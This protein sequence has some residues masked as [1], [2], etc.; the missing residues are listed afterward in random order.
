MKFTRPQKVLFFSALAIGAYQLSR[1]ASLQ[2]AILS[3]QKI[4]ILNP[5]HA[6]V[7]LK[8]ENKNIFDVT[9]NNFS[10]GL[11]FNSQKFGIIDL[12]KG[13][14]LEAKKY[15]IIE[16]PVI[17]DIVAGINILSSM[18]LKKTTEGVINFLGYLSADGVD[19]P[20]NENYKIW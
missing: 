15:K 18:L 12:D 19:I 11:F 17:I 5:S 1:I 13:F 2:K 3:I 7:T 9:I 16:I 14:L 20:I 10:L 4:K 6:I 8:I